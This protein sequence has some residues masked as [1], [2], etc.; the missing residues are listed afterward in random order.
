[1]RNIAFVMDSVDHL[2]LEVFRALESSIDA[3]VGRWEVHKAVATLNTQFR[4]DFELLDGDVMDLAEFTEH[5]A[6]GFL[7]DAGVHLTG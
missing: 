4:V 5:P 2:V 7:G 1:M 6:K 3:I